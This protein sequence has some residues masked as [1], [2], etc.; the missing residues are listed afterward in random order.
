MASNLDLTFIISDL[1][2]PFHKQ[3][4]VDAMSECINKNKHRVRNVI[5]I[6]DEQ[7]FQTISRWAVGT[8]L[9]WEKSIGRDRDK[10]VETLKKL[11][12]TDC[13]RSNHTDRLWMSIRSRLPGLVGLPELEIENFWKLPELGIKFHHRGFEFA[14]D[15]IALHGDESRGISQNAGTTAANLAAK[16][17]GKN[18]VCG[19][20]HR[21]GLVPTT[22][23]MH[24]KITRTLFGVEVGHAMDVSQAKYLHHHNWQQ[25]WAA[26]VHDNTSTFPVL[27]PVVNKSFSFEGEVFSW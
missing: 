24:G 25:G 16:K 7:D 10:T 8:S 12:V 11:S 2:V 13:I 4:F 1:Q 5:T 26:F 19:H 3:A 22:F 27:M 18:V 21:M 23:S 17:V 14:R 9:E 20:T 6:G 15:W